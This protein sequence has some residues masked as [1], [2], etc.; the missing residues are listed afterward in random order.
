ML[1]LSFV[2]RISN[3]T[4]TYSAELVEFTY[5]VKN[6]EMVTFTATVPTLSA[7]IKLV[8]VDQHIEAIKRGDALS[9]SNDD[10]TGAVL[11]LRAV[12]ISV[13]PRKGTAE[14]TCSG[15]FISQTNDIWGTLLIPAGSISDTKT[16]YGLSMLEAGADTHNSEM[17]LNVDKKSDLLLGIAWSYPELR[18]LAVMPF[19]GGGGNGPGSFSS[20][21]GIAMFKDARPG[22]EE[23]DSPVYYVAPDDI[24]DYEI[25]AAQPPV[26]HLRTAALGELGPTPQI[27]AVQVFKRSGTPGSEDI[28]DN[29]RAYYV[30]GK[31][32]CALWVAQ[33][34]TAGNMI[35]QTL[36]W[37][38]GIS[39]TWVGGTKK[40]IV[41]IFEGYY[42]EEVGNHF[43]VVDRETDVAI[44]DQECSAGTSWDLQTRDIPG[45]TFYFDKTSGTGTPIDCQLYMCPTVAYIGSQEWCVALEKRGNS[46]QKI[47]EDIYGTP[48][49][50]HNVLFG[51]ASRLSNTPGNM[52]SAVYI[53]PD[54][55]PGVSTSVRFYF[56]ALRYSIAAPVSHT[57]F[58]AYFD[59][60]PTNAVVNEFTLLDYLDLDASNWFEDTH[61]LF[62]TVTT[63]AGQVDAVTKCSVYSVVG[64]VSSAR[65]YQW[66]RAFFVLDQMAAPTQLSD[67]PALAIKDDTWILYENMLPGSPWL[68]YGSISGWA[69]GSV[70]FFS[71]F[72]GAFVAETYTGDAVWEVYMQMSPL[73]FVTR[74]LGSPT[75]ATMIAEGET[76]MFD[77]NFKI[78]TVQQVGQFDTEIGRIRINL[79]GFSYSRQT[80]T[81]WFE[82]PASIQHLQAMAVGAYVR[83]ALDPDDPTDVIIG[84]VVSFS[85]T[86]DGVVKAEMVAVIVS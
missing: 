44:F 33:E 29:V 25:S 59:Y 5:N 80:M 86:Y 17:F 19:V 53:W 46:V 57:S 35:S 74:A 69:K 16:A 42:I 50:G 39:K 36:Y 9:V 27:P 23:S 18:N 85:F 55:T 60:T 70:T 32:L 2:S 49:Q 75:Q 38:D 8:T 62:R 45:T 15:P 61:F 12:E 26:T 7:V 64:G 31:S 78:G 37:S 47:L 22:S 20:G 52:L 71:L 3:S 51:G 82:D 73:P 83:I 1:E 24:I 54:Y 58:R 67:V 41:G 66:D 28:H 77:L 56:L 76:N 48:L 10:G 21:E 4:V 40:R 65:S 11:Q 79:A 14:I 68:Q 63:P 43:K 72:K 84:K 13:I 34:D 30:Q 81:Q 6:N